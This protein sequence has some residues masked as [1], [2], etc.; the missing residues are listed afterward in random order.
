MR[1][2]I[3]PMEQYFKCGGGG[4]AVLWKRWA[5]RRNNISNVVEVDLQF[6]GK[7]DLFLWNNMKNIVLII[8]ACCLEERGWTC[9]PWQG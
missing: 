8:R 6:Y 7:D 2:M 3:V 5:V 9:L 1:K 4:F